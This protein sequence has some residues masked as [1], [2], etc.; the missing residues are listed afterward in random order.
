VPVALIS[1]GLAVA[2]WLVAVPAEVV[3]RR[4]RPAG[5]D[6]YLAG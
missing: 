5:A 2:L 3:L 4:R 1:T 6:E